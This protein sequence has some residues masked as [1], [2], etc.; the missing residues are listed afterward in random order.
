MSKRAGEGQFCPHRVVLPGACSHFSDSL[1]TRPLP[2]TFADSSHRIVA[3]V[4]PH[5][6]ANDDN[7]R[8]IINGRVSARNEFRQ[9]SFFNLD[10]RLM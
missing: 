1:L 3:A 8:A 9:P 5:V 7:D 4:T 2:Q 6:T 10:V